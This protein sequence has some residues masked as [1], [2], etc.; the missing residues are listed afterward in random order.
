[1]A[2]SQLKKLKESLKSHGLIGNDQ[3]KKGRKNLDK[4]KSR[5]DR[6]DA[7]QNIRAA[8]NPFDVKTT[9]QKQDVL[10]RKVIGAQG[11]PGISKQIGEEQRRVAYEAEMARKNKI[12]G[13]VDRRFGENDAT[14]DPEEKMLARFTAEKLVSFNFLMSCNWHA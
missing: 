1:M 5:I 10:G 7:I 3:T 14:L 8:F 11:K 6:A 2:K 4:H 13:V 9:K 12:G